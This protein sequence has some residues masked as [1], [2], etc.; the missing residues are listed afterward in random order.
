MNVKTIVV[1]LFAVTHL[2]ACTKNET[3]TG[4]SSPFADVP[5]TVKVV[6]QFPEVS[7]I[8]P[9]FTQPGNLWFMQDGGN[10][11]ELNLVSTSGTLV[12]KVFLKGIT[13][14]DWEE[15][16]LMRDPSKNGADLYIADIGNNNAVAQQAVIYRFAEPSATT[17][18]VKS[19]TKIQFTYPDGPRD[20][21][22]FVVDPA[23]MDIFVFSKKDTKSKIYRI[24]FP[25]AD[26]GAAEMVGELP[27]NT[28]VGATATQDGSEILV[29]TY[30]AIYYYKRKT[31][32]TFTQALLK[33]P[34]MLGYQ[35]ELQGESLCFAADNKGFFTVPE[36]PLQG[37][38][39]LSFYKRK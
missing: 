35:L 1:V 10:P 13:N 33:T 36:M 31:G 9:S 2:S 39:L 18:T 7:A 3:T 27:Y 6:T 4:P 24:R 38:Q 14:R 26:N 11:T 20:A 16:I 17:D 29:K 34:V 23:T 30:M 19:F 12:K 15:M 25:Y 5:V 32:E 8:T 28:V 22:A 37:D 21:E